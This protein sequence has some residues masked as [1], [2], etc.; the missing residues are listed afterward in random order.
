MANFDF[1]NL[2]LV[3]PCK[4][5]DEC[6]SRAMHADYIVDNAKVFT[7]FQQSIKNIE[8]FITRKRDVLLSTPSI[9]PSFGYVTSK[10]G[11]RTHPLLKRKEF[12]R[13]IDIYNPLGRRTPVRATARGKV[14]VAGWVGSFGRSVIID[15]G[16]GFSTRYSHCSKLIV[17]QGENVEQGQTIAYVGSTGMSTGNH[18]HYEVWY[19]GKHINPLR[20]V[21][22]R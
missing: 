18:L 4:L 20:F 3:N 15:H 2:Y 5:D 10:Y 7:S 9:W 13:A 22:G 12:H 21:K 11:W 6:Y 8:S 19:R 16:N 14:V 1:K 17:K